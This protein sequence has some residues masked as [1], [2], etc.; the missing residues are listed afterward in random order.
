MKTQVDTRLTALSINTSAEVLAFRMLPRCRTNNM[1]T[2][3]AAIQTALGKQWV[4]RK[5]IRHWALQLYRE[6]AI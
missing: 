6:G 2:V 5:A 4:S 1:V 3:V